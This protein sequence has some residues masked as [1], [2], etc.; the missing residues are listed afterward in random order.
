MQID[1]DSDIAYFEDPDSLSIIKYKVGDYIPDDELNELFTK[2]YGKI[3]ST[4]GNFY[5]LEKSMGNVNKNN[6]RY[7]IGGTK[8]LQIVYCIRPHVS[9]YSPINSPNGRAN[10]GKL[11]E[12]HTN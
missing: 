3:H 1:M 12:T 6:S 10:I 9:A 11:L 4:G 7:V 2:V 5:L 8:G